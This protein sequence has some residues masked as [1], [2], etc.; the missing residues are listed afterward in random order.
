MDR[1]NRVEGHTLEQTLV[2]LL[3]QSQQLTGSLAD[4]GQRVLDAPHLALVAESEV[5]DDLQLLVQ[6]G[7]LVRT[8]RRHVRLGEYRRGT[9]VHHLVDFVRLC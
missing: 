1:L 2:V 9:T 3:L 8:T 5:T 4:L 7:L 6:A